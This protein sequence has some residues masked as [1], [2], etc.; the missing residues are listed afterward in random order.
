M[1]DEI[2]VEFQKTYIAGRGLGIAGKKGD[3]KTYQSCE[4][5]AGLLED[6]TLKAVKKSGAG[7]REK[8]TK[9]A[10]EVS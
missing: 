1:S 2:K 8:A 6:G 3:V 5:V 4:Q 7:K 9:K 10:D